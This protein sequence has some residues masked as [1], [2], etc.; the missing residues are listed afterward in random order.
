MDL[1][2][3]VG[4]Y[5]LNIRASVIIRRKDQILFHHNLKKKHYAL[6]GGRVKAGESSEDAVKR[7]IFE[8]MGKE[9][10]ITGYMGI[11]E[12]FFK[13]EGKKYHEILFV[14]EGVMKDESGENVLQNIEE[15]LD[16]IYE[17]IEEEK[18]TTIELRPDVLK[19]LLIQKEFPFH[20]MQAERI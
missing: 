6:P 19:K 13:N 11:I 8:E 15:D 10:K 12:N 1:A 5:F 16:L 17:W 3:T 2:L 9:I 4:E 7:E 20:K 18:I 14:Y